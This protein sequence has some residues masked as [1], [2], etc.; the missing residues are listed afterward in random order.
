MQRSLDRILSPTRL[1]SLPTIEA[2]QRKI[3]NNFIWGSGILCILLRLI[4][5]VLGNPGGHELYLGTSVFL[6]GFLILLLSERYVHYSIVSLIYVLLVMVSILLADDV[7]NLVQGEALIFFICP[8]ALA[9]LLLRPWAGYVAAGLVSLGVS[10]EVVHLNLGTPNI[11]TFIL[12]FMMALIIQQST[13]R[14][15]GAMEEEQKKSHALSESEAN[16]RRLI[17]LLPVGILINQDGKIVMANPAA[18][19][20][21]GAER[22]EDLIGT[23]IMDYVHPDSRRVVQ[24]R[25]SAILSQGE[26]ADIIEEK[27][28]RR[29]GT[30][31]FA[32][33]AGLPLTYNNKPAILVML[34][35]VTERKRAREAI[36]MQNLRIK[37]ISRRLLEVQEQERHLLA[38]ELHDDLGQSLTSLKL[39][40]EL[41]G[42]ARTTA[43]R[44]KRM[45]E[46]RE[47]ASELM[48]KVRN[49]S[50]DLRP[51]MLDDFGL[52]V[53]L[54]WLFD[55]F[56]SR[57]GISVKC[58]HDLDSKQRFDPH[59]ETAAFRI[60][61]EALT[62]IARYASVKEAKVTLL[63]GKT[64][65]IEIADKGTGFNVA[66]VTQNAAKSAGLSGMQERAHLL[67]GS[68]NIIS[69]PGAGT[70]VIAE[71]P[72]RGA[73]R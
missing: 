61:Q 64:L 8:I 24:E 15:Q 22:Q 30:I 45:A 46:A 62:N 16:S 67:G 48:N 42:K 66:Q 12:F 36:T 40:L 72:L 65:S 55:L 68:V 58:D 1:S 20:L 10:V 27:L 51:A 31:F 6:I 28:T 13:L 4:L 38:A 49:L 53:A 41:S 70:R 26:I 43:S 32:E 59:V 11:P 71:I 60:I 33:T 47:M 44:Q 21:A 2:Y 35:D 18:V 57:T 52:F 56:Q 14:F 73:S 3:L 50:L 69:K 54:R 9:G 34:T 17:D 25:S 5:L 37:E 7:V 63:S 39:M 23:K 19:K 29:D